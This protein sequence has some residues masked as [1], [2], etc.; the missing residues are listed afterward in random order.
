MRIIKYSILDKKNGTEIKKT[1]NVDMDININIK[2]INKVLTQ[3]IY[4]LLTT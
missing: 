2:T 1:L 3:L 4:V